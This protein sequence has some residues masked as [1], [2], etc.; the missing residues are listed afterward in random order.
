M[1]FLTG[2]TNVLTKPLP[3]VLS[4]KAHAYADYFTIG[5]FLLSGLVASRRNRRAAIASFA[6]GAT[7]LAVSLLTDYPGG[8][9][10][11]ISFPLH[12]KIDIGLAAMAATMPEF[13]A[14]QDEPE[15]MFFYAQAALITGLTNLTQ[16]EPRAVRATRERAR[17]A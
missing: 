14:F 13:L 2:I 16:F 5:A 4:P 17:A 9:S 7:E 3:R 6:C 12:E 11:A 1:S 15:R 8:V 10:K